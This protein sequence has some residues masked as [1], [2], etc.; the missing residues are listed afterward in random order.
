MGAK[1]EIKGSESLRSSEPLISPQSHYGSNTKPDLGVF[2]KVSVKK[3]KKKKDF[4]GGFDEFKI[5][6]RWVRERTSSFVAE[7]AIFRESHQQWLQWLLFKAPSLLF[8]SPQ[9]LSWANASRP[10][11]CPEISRIVRT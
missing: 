1:G 4:M 6:A 8:L 5:I 2:E 11:P 9:I 3:K 7:V 10:P